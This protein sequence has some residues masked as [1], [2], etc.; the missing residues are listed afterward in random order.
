MRNTSAG[1]MVG[2]TGMLNMEIRTFRDNE[3]ITG[4]SILAVLK[5]T[6]K[7]EISKCM[8]IEPLLSYSKVVSSLK[9]VNSSIKSIEDLIIK[10]NVVFSN[11]NSR[12]QEK[13]ILSI[14]SILLF[15]QM[16][17]ISVDDGFVFF[18]GENFNFF[19]SD[20]G[21]KATARIK[22]ARNLS[23]ILLKGDASDFYLSLRIEI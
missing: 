4:I 2:K 8:L 3:L 11:F 19:N 1:N 17:L 14:N 9:R 21:D 6:K 22:A 13:L 12:Y 20:L 5:Y 23:E 15:E 7:L 16:G 18:S 10:E